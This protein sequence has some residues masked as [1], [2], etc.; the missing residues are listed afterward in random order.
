MKLSPELLSS[1]PVQLKTAHFWACTRPERSLEVPDSSVMRQLVRVKSWVV[2]LY[3][4]THSVPLD[5][6]AMISESC[7]RGGVSCD[8]LGTGEGVGDGLACGETEGGGVGV[9]VVEGSGE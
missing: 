3:N 5:G 8:V 7:R 2:G 1:E 9:G 4:S 6:Q